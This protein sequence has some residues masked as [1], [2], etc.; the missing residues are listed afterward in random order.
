S[1][2]GRP[3]RGRGSPAPTNAP[4]TEQALRIAVETFRQA[5][6]RAQQVVATDP[7]AKDRRGE[8]LVELG[9]TQQLL[10]LYKEAA[11]TYTQVLNEK[12]VP[13]REEE[14]LQRQA[15]ALHLGG[16]YN[17]SDKGCQRYLQTH[18]TGTL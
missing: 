18:P 11:A 4:A 6:D 1:R 16:D 7:E 15:T 2:R 9:D 14:I 12:I 5:A 10:K 8:I 3:A 17:E 13:Q